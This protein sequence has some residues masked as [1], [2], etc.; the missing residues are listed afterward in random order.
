MLRFGTGFDLDFVLF[1]HFHGDHYLGIVGFLRTMA[2]GG[3]TDALSLYG[4]RPFIDDQLPTLIALGGGG[5]TFPLH[6]RGLSG[7]DRIERDGYTVR[8][9]GVDHRVPAL[10]YVLEE[11]M[12]PGEFQVGHARELGVPEGPLYGRLQ[13]GQ[14][15]TLAD[16][17][18]IHPHDV[19][20]PARRGRK[21]AFS[22][23]TRPCIALAQAASGADL[24]VHDSTFANT[25]Q[26]RAIETGHST[27]AEAAGV[28]VRAGARE[29]LLTHFSS[30]HDAAPEVLADE[31]R[32]EFD[33]AITIGED[34]LATE[35]PFP[36]DA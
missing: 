13:T 20:G 14:E 4:P 34:G 28:A 11:P 1:T 30:R 24:L 23:D 19:L 22:G 15:V 16:G 32:A 17:R 3:R 27:A 33:G 26:A 6:Y 10:G 31:A 29:L 35:I 5:L 2:M 7:D 9:V 18:T 12:R 36:T 25:E 8:A 21:L